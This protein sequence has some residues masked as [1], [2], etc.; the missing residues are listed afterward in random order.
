[1]GDEA[2]ANLRGNQNK[3]RPGPRVLSAQVFE[4]QTR[5]VEKHNQRSQ[6]YSQ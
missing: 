4:T 3:P 6:S 1:M 5:P 2:V